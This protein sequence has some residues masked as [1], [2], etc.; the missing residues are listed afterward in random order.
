MPQ[1][2]AAWVDNPRGPGREKLQAQ[3]TEIRELNERQNRKLVTFFPPKDQDGQ[4]PDE[5]FSGAILNTVVN[6]L[7]QGGFSD[8]SKKAR[9][10]SG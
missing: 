1:L 2:D 6:H 3:L 7:I 5:D 10:C 9:G 4:A 8:G